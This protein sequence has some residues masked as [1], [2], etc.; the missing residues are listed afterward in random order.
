MSIGTL[1]VINLLTIPLI[2]EMEQIGIK[3][4]NFPKIYEFLKLKNC[5]QQRWFY[6]YLLILVF[7][8]AI[9]L[10]PSRSGSPHV[11]SLALMCL[12]LLVQ[13]ALW[14]FAIYRILNLKKKN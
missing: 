6:G 4:K 3:T 2:Y 10:V 13:V 5:F 1:L 9:A 7:F 12:M 14:G 11:A 8:I